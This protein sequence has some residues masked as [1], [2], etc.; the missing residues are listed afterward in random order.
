MKANQY[1]VSK[2]KYDTDGVKVKLPKTLLIDVPA[3]IT[4]E[5]EI[6]EYISDEISN[7]TGYCHKEFE[8]KPEINESNHI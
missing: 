1:K 3:D 4:D 6:E 2:I 7:Q 8:I 5:D